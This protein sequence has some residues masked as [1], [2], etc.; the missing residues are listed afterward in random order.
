MQIIGFIQISGQKGGKVA[1]GYVAYAF[2]TLIG[3][4]LLILLFS[5]AGWLDVQQLA[6]QFNDMLN[7][8][9]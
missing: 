1:I 7:N 2:T 9:R 4:T 5:Q 3:G 8:S 6:E